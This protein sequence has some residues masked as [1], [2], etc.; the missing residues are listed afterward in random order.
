[1]PPPPNA[2]DMHHYRLV[3]LDMQGGGEIQLI[4]KINV[5]S[6]IWTHRTNQYTRQILG[7]LYDPLK[8]KSIVNK[9]SNVIDIISQPI[10]IN[11]TYLVTALTH[12]AFFISVHLKFSIQY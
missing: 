2:H 6:N 3:R 5:Y 9:V 1:M 10:K 12:L 7:Y 11:F 8:D 4:E